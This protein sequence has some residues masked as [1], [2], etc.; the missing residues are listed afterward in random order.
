MTNVF[1]RPQISMVRIGCGGRGYASLR[2]KEV[3]E[4]LIGGKRLGER[5]S[6]SM[7]YCR[8]KFRPYGNIRRI[9]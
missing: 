3:A 1:L 6:K 9:A 8:L 4:T 7:S 2:K 5:N